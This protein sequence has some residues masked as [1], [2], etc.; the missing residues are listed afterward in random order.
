VADSAL[1]AADHIAHAAEA[2]GEARE[3]VERE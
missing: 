1:D 2:L 3:R